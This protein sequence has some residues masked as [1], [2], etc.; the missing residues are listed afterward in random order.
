MAL[1]VFR[2]KA[3]AEIFMFAET[4]QRMLQII[5][6][7]DAQRGVIRGA[8]VAIALQRL[9]DAVD[10]EKSALR[11]AQARQQDGERRGEAGTESLPPITLGQR[12]FPL[13]EMLRA[14]DRKGVDVTWGV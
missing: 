11:D 8:D 13:L 2:S 6:K 4:A 10:A 9:Q 5:G 7:D 14:A 1:V 3:A 12:A